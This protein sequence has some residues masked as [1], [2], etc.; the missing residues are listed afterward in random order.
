MTVLTAQ[1]TENYMEHLPRRGT[2]QTPGALGLGQAMATR[3]YCAFY[4]FYYGMPIVVA[5]IA[6][7]YLGRY[8][9]LVVSVLLYCL[10]CIV[11]TTSSLTV[12]LEK[13]WGIPGLA[14]AMVLI[15]FGGGGFRAIIVPFI[16]DQQTKTDPRL[17]TLKTGELV[18]T[19]H[20]I[21]LQYIYNL[22]YW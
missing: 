20:Q 21:T 19:D 8:A 22:Y 13:G 14:V 10:G 16:A 2:Q 18:I 1:C 11:L 9:T 5:I 6:D 15:G 7:S 17:T 4:L 12:S 3:I